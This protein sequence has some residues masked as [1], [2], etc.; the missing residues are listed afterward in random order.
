[1][2]SPSRRRCAPPP[3][4]SAQFS[5]APRNS[6][7]QLF[8]RAAAPRPLDCSYASYYFQLRTLCQRVDREFSLK[9]MDI[10]TAAKLEAR[11][12]SYKEKFKTEHGVVRKHQ[13]DNNIGGGAPGTQSNFVHKLF[14]S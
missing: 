14:G 7:A 13:S 3:R 8:S 4:N 11:G 5:D 10:E 12:V 9:P 2:T 6:S 1:M